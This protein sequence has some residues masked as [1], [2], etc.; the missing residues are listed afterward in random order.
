MRNRIAGRHWLLMAAAAIVAAVPGGLA[1]QAPLPT[2]TAIPPQTTLPTDAEGWLRLAEAHA[3]RYQEQLTSFV[4]EESYTQQ[5][6]VR[7]SQH[8]RRPTDRR[9]LS[10]W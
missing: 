2:Q 8:H 10:A 7:G 4:A 9:S 6:L 1:A 5:V 3:T